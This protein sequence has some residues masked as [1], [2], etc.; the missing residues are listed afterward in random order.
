MTYHDLGQ[1]NTQSIAERFL[2]RSV[3]QIFPNAHYM[4]FILTKH[5]LIEAE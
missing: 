5:D 3:D 2:D 1:S 4:R